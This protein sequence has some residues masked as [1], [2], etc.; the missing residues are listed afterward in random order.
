MTR[1]PAEGKPALRQ[2]RPSRTGGRESGRAVRGRVARRT[3]ALAGRK[4]RRGGMNPGFDY[5][6]FGSLRFSSFSTSSEMKPEAPMRP[7]MLA[8]CVR[9]SV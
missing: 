9:A 3:N 6:T 1:A 5:G 8:S 2:R 7:V 4:A